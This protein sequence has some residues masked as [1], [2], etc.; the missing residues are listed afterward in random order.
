MTKLWEMFSENWNGAGQ[1]VLQGLCGQAYTDSFGAPSG[2]QLYTA[3]WRIGAIFD[4][5]PHITKVYPFAHSQRVFEYLTNVWY[6]QAMNLDCGNRNHQGRERIDTG[7]THDWSIAAGT[8]RPTGWATG[9]VWMWMSQCGWSE[10]LG[11][12]STG[13]SPNYILPVKSIHFVNEPPKAFMTASNKTTYYT[14]YANVLLDTL[15]HWTDGQWQ[16]WV[17]SDPD[18]V[19]GS[20]TSASLVI[21]GNTGFCNNMMYVLPLLRHYGVSSTIY[22]AIRDKLAVIIPSVDW[23]VELDAT[24]NGTVGN[25]VSMPRC[26]NA[27]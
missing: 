13:W 22:N 2:G 4:Q 11:G 7:Y 15:N 14:L 26:S 6:Y 18:G 5:A 23:Q 16:A 25:P 21:S 10:P 17:A 27:P 19:V 20:C 24:C 12:A 8:T 3:C 9:I 1:F